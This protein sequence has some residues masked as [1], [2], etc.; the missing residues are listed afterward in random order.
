MGFNLEKVKFGQLEEEDLQELVRHWQRSNGLDV[1]GLAGKRTIA[2]IRA[3]RSSEDL[4][5]GDELLP[6]SFLDVPEDQEDPEGPWPIFQS[7]LLP[8]IPRDRQEIVVVFGDPGPVSRPDKRWRKANILSLR[9]LP[10][11]N[12]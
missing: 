8:M 2:S 10:G 3:S 1:D 9:D 7:P 4:E 6:P 5:M 12:R 11:V